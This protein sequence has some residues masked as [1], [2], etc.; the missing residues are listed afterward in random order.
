MAEQ[1]SSSVTSLEQSQAAWT[2]FLRVTKLV[3]AATVVSMVLLAI[4]TL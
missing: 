2:S 3:V 1:T 4:V